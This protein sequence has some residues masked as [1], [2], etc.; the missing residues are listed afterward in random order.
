MN[1]TLTPHDG[2]RQLGLTRFEPT[3]TRMLV[4]SFIYF[5]TGADLLF[6][7]CLL[8]TSVTLE[9]KH[10]KNAHRNNLIFKKTIYYEITNSI[11]G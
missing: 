8:I 6:T 11:W 7:L 2:R 1:R 5:A 3:T 9:T 10:K 4:P